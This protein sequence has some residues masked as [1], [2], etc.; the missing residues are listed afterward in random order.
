MWLHADSDSVARIGFTRTRSH[1]AVDEKLCDVDVKCCRKLKIY[2]S[3]MMYLS[4][5]ESSSSASCSSFLHHPSTPSTTK[6]YRNPVTQQSRIPKRRR[7]R[8]EEDEVGVLC[9]SKLSNKRNYAKQFQTTR[10]RRVSWTGDVFGAE[11]EG[12]RNTTTGFC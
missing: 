6:P 1:Y 11:K 5:S 3:E 10:R 2:C 7:F 12:A 8:R 4:V 9:F